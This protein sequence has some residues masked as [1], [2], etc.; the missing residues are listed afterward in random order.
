MKKKEIEFEF[1]T[2]EEK[3]CIK[4]GAEGTRLFEEGDLCYQCTMDDVF[5]EMNERDN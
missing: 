1:V 3:E 4:C 2:D 5:K